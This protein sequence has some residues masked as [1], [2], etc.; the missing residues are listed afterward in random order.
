[1]RLLLR[2]ETPAETGRREYRPTARTAAAPSSVGVT[3]RCP[4]CGGAQNFNDSRCRACDARLIAAPSERRR[5]R[6]R[7]AGYFALS[8]AAWLW[9][10]LFAAEFARRAATPGT[11]FPWEHFLTACAWLCAASLWGGRLRRGAG[12]MSLRL[13]ARHLRHLLTSPAAQAAAAPPAPY[14]W[15]P[16]SRK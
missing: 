6:A 1:M 2:Q 16:P 15:H 11:P 14:R 8:G 9:G 10:A 7:V 13:R 4:S 3:W 12:E 5:F